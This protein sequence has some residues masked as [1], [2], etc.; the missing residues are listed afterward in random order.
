MVDTLWLVLG[1]LMFYWFVMTIAQQQG[2]LPEQIR[3]QGPITT[4]HTQYGKVLLDRLSQPRRF[5]R[6]Y[7]N[8]GVGIAIVMMAGV[9]L[10]VL[11]AGIQAVVNPQPTV[12]NEPQNVL[13]IPGVNDF[14]PL[15]V[16][17]E[18][19][20]GLLVGLVVHEGGHGLFCR[21]GDIEID[22]MGLAMLAIIPIGAFVEPEEMSRLKADRG[23]QT[24]M[25]AAGVTNNFA[26]TIVGFL[27]LF[28]P[29]MGAVSVAPGA[30]VG[31]IV[32]GSPADQAGIE[33]GDR[34]TAINGESVADADALNRRL[35]EI[36]DKTVE[37]TVAT[38]DGERTERVTRELFVTRS[39]AGALDGAANDSGQPVHIQSVNGSNVSTR[40]ELRSLLESNPRVTVTTN[41]TEFELVGGAAVQGLTEESPLA[42]RSEI[43]NA[44]QFVITRFDGERIVSADELSAALEATT[45]GDTVQVTAV[46]DGEKRQFTTTLTDGPADHGYIG[47]TIIPGIGGNTIDDFGIFEYPAE[48]FLASLGGTS[49]LSPMG[50]LSHS[51]QALSLPFAGALGA[52]SYNFAG[53]VEP[54]TNFYTVEGPLSFL[55]GWLFLIANLLFWTGWIN[56]NLGFFNCVPAYPLDGGHILRSTTEAV[57]SRL[58]VGDG[59]RLTRMVTTTIGLTMGAGLV[60]MVFG[61]QLFGG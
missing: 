26:V 28:G 25:F 57:V 2:W 19:V 33:R 27:L 49:G 3:T 48:Q 34:I 29:V 38:G 21:V 37:V 31:D 11:I 53:F 61:P 18:I 55:G 40:A 30:P 35:T 6:A 39:A 50:F 46:V 10:M 51:I 4:L 9:F 5:W 13:V 23:S 36:E 16:A 52:T 32:T 42:N 7:G 45:P 41:R 17:P 24:R 43:T 20:F 14:L 59:R 15:S 54:V 44:S 22:S 8:F 12:V 47:V 56:I 1:G 58:N 60:L